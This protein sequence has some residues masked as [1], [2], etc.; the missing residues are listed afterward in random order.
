MQEKE[1]MK[2]WK[3]AI[4]NG[5]IHDEFIKNPPNPKALRVGMYLDLLQTNPDSIPVFFLNV[6][7]QK[8]DWIHKNG[9]KS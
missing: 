2:L 1:L 5:D 3:E 4:Q 8:L 6:F 9:R 7:S